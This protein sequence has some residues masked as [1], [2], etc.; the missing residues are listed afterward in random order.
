[1][2]RFSL[3]VNNLKDPLRTYEGDYMEQ[4][5]EYVKLFKRADN[6]HVTDTQVAAIHLIHLDKNHSVIKLEN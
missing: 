5:G 4:N 3:V 1:M 6:P 2:A